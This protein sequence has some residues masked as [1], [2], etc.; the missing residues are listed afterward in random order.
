MLLDGKYVKAVENPAIYLYDQ[1]K[2]LLFNPDTY[3]AWG[4]R[5]DYVFNQASLDGLPIAQA[6]FLAKTS[7][8]TK[9]MMA[10]GSKKVFDAPTL[11]AYGYTDNAFTLITDRAAARQANAVARVVIRG[12]GPEAYLVFGGRKLPFSSPA[13]LFATGYNWSSIDSVSNQILSSL[14]AG[15]ASIGVGSLIRLPTGQVSVIDEG[16]KAYIINSLEEFYALGYPWGAVRYVSA[17]ALNGY[18]FSPMSNILSAGGKKYILDLGKIYELTTAQEADYITNPSSV[19][20]V[21]PTLINKYP[22]AQLT[23]FIQGS[24]FTVYKVV[25]GQKLPISSPVSLFA[26]GGTWNSIV[27]VSDRLLQSLPVGSTL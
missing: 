5:L 12:S 19:L 10:F 16:G 6:P 18:D 17:G 8:G 15:P 9:M 7:G 21:T 24:G 13:D 4:G 1:G 11:S 27:R 23:S 2:L 3:Q 25:D 22:R 20:A 26:N 14:P